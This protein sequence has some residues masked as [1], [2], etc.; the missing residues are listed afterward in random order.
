MKQNISNLVKKY[1]KKRGM[2]QEKLAEGICTQAIISKIEKGQTN[3]SVDIFSELCKKLEISSKDILQILELDGI[4]E[5]D[6]NVFIKEYRQLYYDRDYKSIKFFLKHLINY[7]EL[8]EVDKVYYEWLTAVVV[9]YYDKDQ[10]QGLNSLLKIYYSLEKNGEQVKLLD[11]ITQS[12]AD[13]NYQMQ[14]YESD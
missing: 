6:E 3:L 11:R 7:E 12:L 2:T 1:R 10:E 14:Q 5:G 4:E 13:M 9:F 8:S